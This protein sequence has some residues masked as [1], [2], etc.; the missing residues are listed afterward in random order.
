MSTVSM[1]TMSLRSAAFPQPRLR[2][3]RRG[4]AVLTL[5][6][7]I[8]LAIGAAVTGV[9]AIG[10]AAGSH[11]SS[12]TYQY[13]TVESGESLWQVA[14]QV[15]PNADPREVIA[16]ILSLNNLSSGDVQAGQRLA[17]PA[18]YSH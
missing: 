2:I 14:E 13:V 15:A 6:I 17:I 4:R 18:Q 5:L 11:S 8:P 12:A 1:S 7:A 16:D 9:G 10:A 3:T